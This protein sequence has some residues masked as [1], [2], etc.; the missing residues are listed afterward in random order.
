MELKDRSEYEPENCECICHKA[1]FKAH[2]RKP[3]CKIDNCEKWSVSNGV[4]I[5]HN[6]KRAKC[7]VKVL[8]Y[9]KDLHDKHNDYPFFPIHKYITNEDLS[10]YQNKLRKI[11]KSRKLVTSLEDKEGLICDY[12]TL[13]QVIKHGL[14][15]RGIDCA[16]NSGRY[17]S[18][19]VSKV[20]NQKFNSI[21]L[22]DSDFIIGFF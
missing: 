21:R 17:E 16:I 22:I 2:K 11:T 6:A 4:C 8:E 1:K 15:L 3:T 12:K 10:P 9:P 19:R 20:P 5:N 7:R 18:S 14:K 13:K